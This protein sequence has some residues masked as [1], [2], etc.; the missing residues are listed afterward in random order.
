MCCGAGT[1]HRHSVVLA[2]SDAQPGSPGPR[3]QRGEEFKIVISSETP[4]RK[5]VFIHQD[6]L[7]AFPFGSAQPLCLQAARRSPAC[8][9]PL[10][11]SPYAAWS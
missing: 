6:C 2:A 1:R 9:E 7:F 11:S 5:A 8:R 4:T 10:S 3:E